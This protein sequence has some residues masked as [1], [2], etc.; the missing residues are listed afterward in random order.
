MLLDTGFVVRKTFDALCRLAKLSPKILIESRPPSNLLALAEAQLGVA[1]IP[2]AVTTHRYRLRVTRITH[3]R[4]PLREPLSIVWDNRRA[5]PRYAQDFAKL[6]AA[7][8]RERGYAVDA[9]RDGR[10]KQGP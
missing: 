2:S 1:I 8:M 9:E 6:L 7:H 4:K 10:A 3:D 5:L